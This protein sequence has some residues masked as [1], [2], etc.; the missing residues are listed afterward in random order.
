MSSIPPP[1][2][3]PTLIA[4]IWE[5]SRSNVVDGIFSVAGRCVAG[6]GMAA[7]AVSLVVEPPTLRMLPNGGCGCDGC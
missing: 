1:K 7:K 2:S 4:D 6:G 5:K 3:P